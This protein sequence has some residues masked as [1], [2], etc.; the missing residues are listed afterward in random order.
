LAEERDVFETALCGD[1]GVRGE[2]AAEHQ[3]VEFTVVAE[4]ML[5]SVPREEEERKRRTSGGCRP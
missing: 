2:D 1:G 5:V 3:D 4:A